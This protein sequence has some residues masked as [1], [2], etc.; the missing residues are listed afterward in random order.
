MHKN[1][2]LYLV[3][4]AVIWS[5][6]L[7]GVVQ[8]KPS[9]VPPEIDPGPIVK[10]HPVLPP[11]E[12]PPPIIEEIKTPK[13]IVR[14]PRIP[15]VTGPPP[16]QPTNPNSDQFTDTGSAPSIGIG[17][18]NGEGD[19][20]PV[21]SEVVVVVANI[22]NERAVAANP[23]QP[24]SVERAY[25]VRMEERGIT[26]LVQATLD[27]DETG[28]PIDVKILNSTNSG[29][30]S[31]VIREGMK[32]KFRPARKNCESTA[33]TWALNVKFEIMDQ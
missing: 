28:K 4:S 32:M 13:P 11:P 23:L 21:A 2:G 26:G 25:P 30:D 33:G 7:W 17:L 6:L 5:F 3:S 10:W 16:V 18:G 29:F 14:V 20:V 19:I 12:P 27:I 24:F 9:F 15:T 22:C 1:R 8:I 31:A